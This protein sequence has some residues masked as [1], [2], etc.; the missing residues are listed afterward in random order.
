MRILTYK[1]THTGDPDHFGRFGINDCM[2]SVRNLRFDAVIGVGGIG[3]EPHTFGIA[4]KLTW[5]G[6]GP[7]RSSGGKGRRGDIVTFD[8]FLL[9]DAAGPELSTVAPNLARRV[10]SRRIRFV[11]DGYSG[12]EYAEALALLELAH[13]A[14]PPERTVSDLLWPR[15]KCRRR[16]KSRKAIVSYLA[17]GI[18]RPATTRQGIHTSRKSP[19]ARNLSRLRF[20]TQTSSY[21]RGGMRNSK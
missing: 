5:I 12:V 4:R 14:S 15:S 16:C 7:R 18:C 6:I 21:M 11:L 8:R 9:L 13:E 19:V 3:G 2:G 20:G 17:T 10:Y 1:R